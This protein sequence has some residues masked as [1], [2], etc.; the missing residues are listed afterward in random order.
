MHRA[1]F[2]EMHPDAPDVHEQAQDEALERF[3]A[4]SRAARGRESGREP[5][6]WNDE[7]DSPPF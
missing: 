4:A 1:E 7:Y 3:Y 6:P 2:T 5:L